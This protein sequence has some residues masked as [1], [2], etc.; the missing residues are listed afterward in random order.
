MDGATRTACGGHGPDGNR[1]LRPRRRAELAAWAARGARDPGA[2]RRRGAR[3]PVN[4]ELLL[5]VDLSMAS[6]WL[7]AGVLLLLLGRLLAAAAA[8]HGWRPMLLTK[9]R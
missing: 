9:E 3:G 1:S 7:L 2:P 4:G 5:L 8:R 6:S